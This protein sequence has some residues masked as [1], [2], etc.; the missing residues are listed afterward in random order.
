MLD[1][2]PLTADTGLVATAGVSG[3]TI[4]VTFRGTAELPAVA[5]MNAIVDKLHAEAV[6]V[7]VDEI[8]VDFT[9]L[10]FM[11][12]SCFKAL[13]TWISAI[14]DLPSEQRYRLRFRSNPELLWQRRSLHVLKTFATELVFV[15]EG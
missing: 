5:A 4:T 11:S 8:V 9:Q 6:A 13:V 10:E 7:R 2:A 1:L 3:R 15:D 14:V 12:S